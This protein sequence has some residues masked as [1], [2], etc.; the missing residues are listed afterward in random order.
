MSVKISV[1]DICVEAIIYLL[2]YNLHDCIF[3][4]LQ[5]VLSDWAHVHGSS[6]VQRERHEYDVKKKNQEP[7]SCLPKHLCRVLIRSHW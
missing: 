4:L 3:K 5:G 2:F 1:V 7:Q 6:V